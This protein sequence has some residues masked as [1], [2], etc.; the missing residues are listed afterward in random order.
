[1]PGSNYDQLV[2]FI[3][4]IC[5]QPLRR[6]LYSLASATVTPGK[7]F[8]FDSFLRSEKTS[9]DNLVKRDKI[10]QS[11]Y[12]RIYHIGGKSNINDLDVHSLVV[13]LQYLFQG[14]LSEDQTHAISCIQRRYYLLLILSI[15]ATDSVPSNV[16][17]SMWTE[18]EEATLTL[19]DKED[20]TAGDFYTEL[21]ELI[22]QAKYNSLP[23]APSYIKAWYI[24]V[25][26]MQGQTDN[27]ESQ[28]FQCKLGEKATVTEEEH[29]DHSHE[30]LGADKTA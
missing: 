23:N 28:C 7:H 22:K 13:L 14:V 8:D 11:Q 6:L 27:E 24:E 25:S 12:H 2:V 5:P 20:E 3:Q 16:F 18:L 17:E 30:I 26:A 9:L 15:T 21:S 4:F 10:S 19:A 29:I 1:M